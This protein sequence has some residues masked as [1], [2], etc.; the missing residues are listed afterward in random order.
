MNDQKEFGFWQS[1]KTAPKTG[2]RILAW[3]P[4]FKKLII[5]HYYKEITQWCDDR[6]CS[7]RVELTHW[8]P[9]PPT[10]EKGGKDWKLINEAPKDEQYILVWWSPLRYPT[11]A[12]YWHADNSGNGWWY[13]RKESGARTITEPTHFILLPQ[14]PTN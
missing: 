9:L 11:I 7:V 14:I 13:C 4:S 5:V 3:G 10:P 6:S 2:V 8:M 1:F 12:H